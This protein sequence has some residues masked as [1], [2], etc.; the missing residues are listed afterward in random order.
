MRYI[1]ILN[2]DGLEN[3]SSIHIC[4]KNKAEIAESNI[5]ANQQKIV[6]AS[7]IIPLI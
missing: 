2:R 5:S 1:D 7:I 6:F 3:L 4:R